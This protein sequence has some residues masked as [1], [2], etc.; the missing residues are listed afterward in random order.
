[1]GIKNLFIYNDTPVRRDFTVAPPENPGDFN[2]SVN[3]YIK[4]KISD[5]QTVTYLEGLRGFHL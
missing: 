5:T 2:N 4:T 3:S 1:M